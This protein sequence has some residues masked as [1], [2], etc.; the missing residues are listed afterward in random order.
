[1]RVKLAVR[2]DAGLYRG[3]GEIQAERTLDALRGIGVEASYFQPHDLDAGDLVHFFGPF[4]YYWDA[5]AIL[6]ERGVPYVV[7]PIFMSPASNLAIRARSFRRGLF[8]RKRQSALA[9]LLSH[10]KELFVLSADE[11][12]RLSAAFGRLAP[13]TVVPNGVDARFAQGDPEEFC[14]HWGRREPFVLHCGRFESRKNQLGLIAALRDLGRP[15]V[16]VGEATEPEYFE[17]CR[18]AGGD[19]TFL[20]A[21]D[22]AG[23][24]LPAV[25]AA[26]KVFALPSRQE[27]LS[28]AALEAGVAGTP[29]VLSSTWGAAEHFGQHARYVRPDRPDDIRRGVLAAWDDQ[30][31]R[32]ARRD[33]F[34]RRFTWE[35]VARQLAD[36]YA[37]ALEGR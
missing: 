7:A 10:A 6:L 36:R 25:Y 32:G 29:L 11:E 18:R 9:N 4:P 1:M 16:F 27:I 34:G 26:A 37:R 15:I 12:R 30:G 33:Y 2:Y 22:Y 5:A 31:D 13:T 23:P 17:T 19:C 8:D 35:A 3:G 14:R 28:L 21:I 20:G 24:L